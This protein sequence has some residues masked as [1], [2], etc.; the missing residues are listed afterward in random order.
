MAT[1]IETVAGVHNKLSNI[2]TNNV[3]LNELA[4]GENVGH[5]TMQ[6]NIPLFNDNELRLNALAQLAKE[7]QEDEDIATKSSL[8]LKLLQVFFVADRR[9]PSGIE[10]RF[11]FV[12][13]EIPSNVVLPIVYVEDDEEDSDDEDDDDELNVDF[14]L[15]KRSGRYYRRYPWKRQ[16]S[17][18]RS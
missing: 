4:L 17:R 8:L 14:Y 2:N 3:N 18:S 6:M 10:K 11:F 5:Q 15:S 1:D 16:N 7:I 12:S 13:Q 9:I